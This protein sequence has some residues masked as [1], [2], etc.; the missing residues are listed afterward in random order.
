MEAIGQLTGGV[1]H[2]F[3]NLLTVIIG[4]LDNPAR[5]PDDDRPQS[6]ARPTWRC[7]GRSAPPSLTGRLL[8]FARRQPLDPE[9]ARRQSAR[10]RH[11][12][13]AAPDAGRDHRARGRARRR[14]SG[15]I[16]ADQNQLE[17]AILNLAVNARDA[18]PDG[19]K[20]T[21]ETANTAS[22][23]VLCR[24][25]DAEVIPGQYV[26]YRVSDTGSG[27]SKATLAAR[28]RAVLHHQGRRP[29]HRASDSAWSTASSSSRAATSRSTASKGR[30]RRQALLPALDGR[31]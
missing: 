10:A 7:R 17:S 14:G 11:D 1:A 24:A 15:R 25:Q 8:A 16:E 26:M 5:L 13:P 3:N 4:G 19:G 27:M 21:I 23:R 22:R 2:D 28:L 12:R 31:D 30:A 20:L 18:M 9:A 29:R 6:S